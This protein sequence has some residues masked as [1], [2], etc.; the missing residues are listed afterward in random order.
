MGRVKPPLKGNMEINLE[1][2]Q[3]KLAEYEAAYK[4]HLQLADTNFGAA[5]AT[6]KMIEDMQKAEAKDAD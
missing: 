2:L 4:Q 3:R 1:Y 5:E 6:K